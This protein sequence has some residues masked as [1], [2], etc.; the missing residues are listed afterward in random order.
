MTKSDNI[1]KIALKAY[2]PSEMGTHFFYRKAKAYIDPTMDDLARYLRKKEICSHKTIYQLIY[3]F[4]IIER[5][6]VISENPQQQLDQEETFM[7]SPPESSDR[8]VSPKL[9]MGTKKYGR[10]SRPHNSKTGD[11]SASD[12]EDSTEEKDS[13][14]HRSC[15]T[16]QVQRSTSQTDIPG[17]R[18]R[19]TVGVTE[20]KLKRCASLPAQRNLFNQNKTKF[21]N[22]AKIVNDSLIQLAKKPLSSSVESLGKYYLKQIMI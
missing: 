1:A 4:L 14:S 17:T 19:Q 18:R 16:Q 21:Q 22:K 8:E 2:T 15:I 9:V 20:T 11:A 6:L 5:S 3:I 12:S 7:D 13:N 10:R